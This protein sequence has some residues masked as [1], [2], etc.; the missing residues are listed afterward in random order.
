MGRSTCGPL[1]GGKDGLGNVPKGSTA[2]DCRCLAGMPCAVGFGGIWMLNDRCCCC[3][4]GAAPA[5]ARTGLGWTEPRDALR[6]A[7][8]GSCCCSHILASR[9]CPRISLLSFSLEVLLLRV[10]TAAC[11]RLRTSS[12]CPDAMAPAK[13]WLTL[14]WRLAPGKRSWLAGGP[15]CGAGL[16]CFGGGCGSGIVST[17]L[18]CLRWAASPAAAAAAATAAGLACKTCCSR[19]PF[20]AA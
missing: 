4:F 1:P 3:C 6:A 5:G 19:E 2:S 20:L 17:L 15:T 11:I 7:G 10:L 16:C 12:T 13:S 9:I 8:N 18:G 14:L